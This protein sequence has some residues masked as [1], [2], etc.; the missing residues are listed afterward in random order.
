MENK[1]QMTVQGKGEEVLLFSNGYGCDQSMWRNVT[2]AFVDE[3]KVVTF[4]HVGSGKSDVSFYSSEKYGSLHGYAEDVIEIIVSLGGDPVHYVGHSVSGMIGILAANKRPELFRE[5]ILIGP[6]A[7]YLNDY[8]DYIGGFEEKDLQEL[9]GLMEAN[10]D[11]WAKYLA[12]IVM[13][14]ED[15][16]YLKQELVDNFTTGNKEISKEFARVTFYCDHRRDVR[17]VRVPVHILQTKHDGVVPLEA[18][19]YLVET[20]PDASIQIMEATGHYPQLSQPEE[21]IRHI[22]SKVKGDDPS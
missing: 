10:F 9:F 13:E 18:A 2:P 19:E 7:R 22:Q 5:L 6:S 21:T 15:R 16:P 4:N 20:I 8:P 14:N 1:H 12:P 3:Y 11:E 17:H